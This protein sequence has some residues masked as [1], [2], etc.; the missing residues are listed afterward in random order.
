MTLDWLL[1]P[2]AQYAFLALALIGSLTLFHL[3]ENGDRRGAAA[4]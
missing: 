4:H 3:N 1:S 2:I